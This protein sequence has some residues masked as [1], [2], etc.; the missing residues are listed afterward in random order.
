MGRHSNKPRRARKRHFRLRTGAAEMTEVTVAV[1]KDRVGTLRKYAKRISRMRQADRD[2]VVWLLRRQA[3]VLKSRFG[4]TSLALFGSVARGESRRESDVDLLVEFAPGRPGGMLEFVTLK[5]W[6]ESI[7][8]RPV[9]LVTPANI[10][11][12]IRQRIL[13]ESVR[14]I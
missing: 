12:R 3:E 7:V 11:P 8:N 9:D 4:V 6:L 10:K 2:Q 14:V 5:G 13:K 1:P